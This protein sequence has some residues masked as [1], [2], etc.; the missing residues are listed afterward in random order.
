MTREVAKEMAHWRRAAPV[1]TQSRTVRACSVGLR[2]LCRMQGTAWGASGVGQDVG[3]FC[4][5]PWT[6]GEDLSDDRHSGPVSWAS[7][8][9]QVRNLPAVVM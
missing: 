9:N 5:P 1:S 7:A 6:D 4:L 8:G 3:G 2:L